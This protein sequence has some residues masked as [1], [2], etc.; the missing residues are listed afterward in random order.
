MRI[1][2]M[3]VLKKNGIKIIYMKANPQGDWKVLSLEDPAKATEE[4]YKALQDIK[5][6]YQ[7][8]RELS[9]AYAKSIYITAIEFEYDGPEDKP[10]I[11]FK[12]TGEKGLLKLT[13]S[14]EV[15]T[16]SLKMGDKDEKDEITTFLNG[17]KVELINTVLDEIGKYIEGERA[18][19][20][21]GI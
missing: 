17:P 11:S 12:I 4:F 21:T 7:E 10:I 13:G 8:M 5:P 18:Q 6:I 20:D 2:K 14:E 3:S 16:V 15:K 19:Q 1:K 9:A